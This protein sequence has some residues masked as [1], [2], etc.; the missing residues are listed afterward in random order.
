M[1]KIMIGD[2]M[3]ENAHYKKIADLFNS[4]NVSEAINNSARAIFS[5][6]EG[7][8]SSDEMEIPNAIGWGKLLAGRFNGLLRKS[9]PCGGFEETIS[10][11]L[12]EDGPVDVISFSSERYLSKFVMDRNTRKIIGAFYIEQDWRE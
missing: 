2:F 5:S 10:A 4:G 7:I 9:T 8:N 6:V 3:N 12:M 1:V 11:L